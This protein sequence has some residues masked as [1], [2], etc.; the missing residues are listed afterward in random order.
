[1]AAPHLDQRDNVSDPMISLWLSRSDDTSIKT[2]FTP[3]E[4]FRARRRQAEQLAARHAPIGTSPWQQ[5]RDYYIKAGEGNYDNYI[6]T[7]RR[8]KRFVPKP[9]E[10]P[11]F[12]AAPKEEQEQALK[13]SPGVVRNDRKGNGN[14]VS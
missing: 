9:G 13:N 10:F 12:D 6:R 2:P 14:I 4:L 7:G 11:V 1:M 8:N 5:W 3:D